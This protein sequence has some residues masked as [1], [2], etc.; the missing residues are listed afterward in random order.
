MGQDEQGQAHPQQICRGPVA[1]IMPIKHLGT[2]GGGFFGAIR[3][4]PSR[5]PARGAISFRS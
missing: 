1:A 5:T 3:P 2:N 4:I